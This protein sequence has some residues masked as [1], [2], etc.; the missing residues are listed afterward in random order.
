[1]LTLQIK[2]DTTI[3]FVHCQ[4]K[5][6]GNYSNISSNNNKIQEDKI[7]MSVQRNI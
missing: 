6:K 7:K 2:R 5:S 3:I 4:Y 1:M